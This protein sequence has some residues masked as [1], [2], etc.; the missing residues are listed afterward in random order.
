MTFI[1]E[2]QSLLR[3]DDFVKIYLR[4]LYETRVFI[5][6]NLLF[7]IQNQSFLLL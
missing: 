5:E 6:Q 2:T 3:V 7:I 4:Y 1:I